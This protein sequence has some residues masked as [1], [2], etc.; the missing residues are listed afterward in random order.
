MDEIKVEIDQTFAI[1]QRMKNELT[2]TMAKLL[3]EQKKS[4]ALRKQ[5]LHTRLN[6]IDFLS[7]LWGA[8]HKRAKG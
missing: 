4:E 1:Q 7:N 5:Y 2:I 8:L 3:V 6:S